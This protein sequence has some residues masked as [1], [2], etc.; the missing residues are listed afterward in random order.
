MDI[1]K[2]Q[3]K[4]R[5]SAK[6]SKVSVKKKTVPVS[7]AK[8]AGEKNVLGK[9]TKTVKKSGIKT[10][11]KTA[12]IT[13]TKLSKPKTGAR[14]VAA[15]STSEIKEPLKTPKAKKTIKEKIPAGKTGK[16]SVK[17]T[18]AGKP[19]QKKPAKTIK[20]MKTAAKTEGTT[21]R[22][23]TVAKTL[24]KTPGK[25]TAISKTIPPKLPEE[26]GENELLLMEV[27]PSTVFVSLEIKPKDISGETGRLVLRVYDV[28]GLDFDSSHANGFFDIPL[29]NRV[30]SKFI[31]IKMP[32]KEVIM[33]IGLLHPDGAFKA[34]KQ[35]NR[36]SMPALQSLKEPG[37]GSLPDSDTLIGY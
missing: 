34:I 2:S 10:P 31:D 32:G 18:K 37:I 11:L 8:T 1:K 24:K 29:R 20:G 14:P 15:K 28:T 33:E 6:G 16:T 5:S 17:I 30:D 4:T 9:T 35:S 13:K 7:T 22:E 26:Y 27:D 25:K 3:A 21:K 23:K 36:V 12:K 19:P